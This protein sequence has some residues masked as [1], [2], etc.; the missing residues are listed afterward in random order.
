[1]LTLI[2][3]MIGLHIEKHSDGTMTCRACR[4]DPCG[5]KGASSA[6]KDPGEDDA[7]IATAM[8]GAASIAQERAIIVKVGDVGAK[9]AR[10]TPYK[11]CFV[12]TVAVCRFASFVPFAAANMK[13]IISKCDQLD[14]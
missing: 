3:V 12:E 7:A 6:A 1:L 5:R 10:C 2:V 8:S 14:S 4:P 9:G 11:L 13:F